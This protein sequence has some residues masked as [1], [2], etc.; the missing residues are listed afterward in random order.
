MKH[1]YFGIVIP[2]RNRAGLVGLLLDLVIGQ[3][4]ANWEKLVVSGDSQRD[5]AWVVLLRLALLRSRGFPTLVG[6]LNPRKKV[7]VELNWASIA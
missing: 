2:A 3:G 6:R 1:P 7:D 4:F 5:T